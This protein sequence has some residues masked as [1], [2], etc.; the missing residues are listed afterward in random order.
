MNK[1]LDFFKT[2]KYALIWTACYITLMWGILLG[3]FN[4]DIFSKAQWIR[5]L[6]AELRG[7]PGFVFGLLML[8]A[9]PLYVATTAI[10]IRTKKPLFTIPL[11]KF[12][13]PVAEEKKELEAEPEKKEEHEEEKDTFPQGLPAELRAPFL[14]ARSTINRSFIKS[15][16]DISNV[17]ELQQKNEEPVKETIAATQAAGELPLPTDFNFESENLS[18]ED[19]SEGNFSVPNFTPVFQDINF[20]EEEPTKKAPNESAPNIQDDLINILIKQGQEVNIDDDLIIT[21]NIVIAIHNDSDFWIADNEDWFAA[22][23]RKTSPI[24]KLLERTSVNKQVPVLYLAETNIMDLE[25]RC[26]EWESQGIK[27]IKNLSDLET[28]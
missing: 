1:I 5:L 27:I 28:I 25:T 12:L 23:K 21:Q 10:I 2:N 6:H 20:D 4:F 24:K 17:T 7:F 22:G 19:F 3:L 13:Q 15:N 9:L 16:F 11:P 18:E 14:R 8:A 26:A